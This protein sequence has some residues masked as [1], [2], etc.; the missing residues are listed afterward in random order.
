L[1]ADGEFHLGALRPLRDALVEAG[2]TRVHP[3]HRGGAVI[4]L[5]WA[6]VARYMQQTG[7]RRL[8]RCASMPLDTADQVCRHDNHR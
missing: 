3:D 2:Q 7:F 6:A 8:A 5:M 4:N 1:Y